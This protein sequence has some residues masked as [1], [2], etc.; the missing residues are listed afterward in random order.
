MIAMEMRNNDGVDL[1]AVDPRGFQVAVELA[2]GALA[3]LQVRLARA[4]IHHHEF[5]ARVDDDGRVGNG[6]HVGARLQKEGGQGLI[7]LLA[8]LVGDE[9]VGELEA[10]DT[11]GDDRDLVAANLV[12]IPPRILG[13]RRRHPGPRGGDWIEEGRA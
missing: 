7:H 4:R 3:A 10:I 5:A 11:V 2:G 1:I 9:V 6:N 12:T 8:R 13:G